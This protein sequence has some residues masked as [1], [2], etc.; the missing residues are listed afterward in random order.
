MIEGPKGRSLWRGF[1]RMPAAGA[2][3]LW[4]A[5]SAGLALAA[6]QGIPQ[7]VLGVLVLFVLGAYCTARPRR[8]ELVGWIALAPLPAAIVASDLGL[9]AG[10][11][12]YPTALVALVAIAWVERRGGGPSSAPPIQPEQQP[13]EQERR[14]EVA[15]LDAQ[16]LVLD[17][18]RDHPGDE[19]RSAQQPGD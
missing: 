15:G 19:Q 14:A 13:A 17:D 4:Y 9:P 5:I 1:M 7:F 2:I 12:V 18:R 11:V 6:P 3:A 10:T 16:H 8:G